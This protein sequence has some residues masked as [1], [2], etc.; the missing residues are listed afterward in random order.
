M[1]EHPESSWY[2]NPA[3]RNFSC[4]PAPAAVLDFHRGMPGY[5]PTGLRECPEL[6]AELA[7][8]RVFVKEE[9]RRF[10]LPAFKMVGA[11]WAL[12]RELAG[13]SGE[14]D[15]NW[16][17]AD[18][19]GHFSGSLT[20]VCATDGNHGRAVARTA[21]LLGLPAR[22]FVPA[23]IGRAAKEGILGEGA[24]LV[25]LD[26][27]YDDVVVKAA[28][29]AEAD[30]AAILVQDTA[31]PGYEAIPGRIVEGY[32][33]IFREIDAQ[34][35]AAGVRVPEG[36]GTGS[37]GA[38]ARGAGPDLVVTPCGV[39]SLI[40]ATVAHY[41]DRG[42]SGAATHP[43]LLSVEPDDAACLLESLKAGRSVVVQTGET[44]MAGLNCGTVSSIAWP[45]LRGGIDAAV[46]ITEDQDLQAVKD[47]ENLG[48]DSGP[49][50]AASLAGL[51]IALGDAGM[52]AGMRITDESV[53]VL[54]STESREANPVV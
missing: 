34:L 12:Y 53:V 6:A 20:L 14:P 26:A 44:R 48:F 43:A 41:R 3:A 46:A 37:L 28:A 19:A 1:T 15:R 11:S 23:R 54:L 29:A 47:L 39:G 17:L 2:Q 18:L 10:G 51:R 4:D 21:A 33:T 22:V 49:C 35:E 8:G 40:Q 13:R 42:R 52:R 31:W 7:V 16:S 50:G 24:E 25:E 45:L 30:P 5:A 32:S 38:E 9:S 27:P 36:G